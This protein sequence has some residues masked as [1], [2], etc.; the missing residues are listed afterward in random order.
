MKRQLIITLELILFFQA[1]ATI[2]TIIAIT[3]YE[4]GS[5]LY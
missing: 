2:L 5:V 1:V 4:M 3:V